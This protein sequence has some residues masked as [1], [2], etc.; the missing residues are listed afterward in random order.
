M[1]YHVRCEEEAVRRETD[2]MNLRVELEQSIGNDETQFTRR[3][4]SVMC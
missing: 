2:E 4:F 1:R 3:C